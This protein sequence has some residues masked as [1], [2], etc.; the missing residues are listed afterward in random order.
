MIL[1]DFES[2]TTT[3]K[4]LMRHHSKGVSFLSLELPITI[5]QIMV[6]DTKVI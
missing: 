4:A 6:A 3:L 1:A 2:A 5:V